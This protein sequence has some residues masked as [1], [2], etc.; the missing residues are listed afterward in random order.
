MDINILKLLP[1]V[2]WSMDWIPTSVGFW[3]QK[4]GTPQKSNIQQENYT[5]PNVKSYSLPAI[6]L[7]Y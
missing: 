2:A 5:K 3:I 7:C 4:P 1:A 6:M